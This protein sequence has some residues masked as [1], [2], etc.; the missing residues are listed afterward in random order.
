MKPAPPNTLTICIA[1]A[2]FA[3]AANLLPAPLAVVASGLLL[4]LL[5]AEVD[6]SGRLI[7]L[8]LVRSAAKLLPSRIREGNEAQWTDHVLCAGEMGLRPV[9]VALW[10]V[11]M[12]APRLAFRYRVRTRAA[13]YVGQ[14]FLSYQDVEHKV[15][16]PLRPI[17]PVGVRRL[18]RA[19]AT[20]TLALPGATAVYIC[21]GDTSRFPAS[22]L[23]VIGALMWTIPI[24]SMALL[25]GGALLGYA[26][27][28][29]MFT[30]T[31]GILIGSRVLFTEGFAIRV[32]DRIAG[33]TDSGSA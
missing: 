10:I 7:A 27:I 5:A 32:V 12:G 2:A 21:S 9:V 20:I 24:G 30:F 14:L 19:T 16:T 4:A 23:A 22:L 3:A 33:R 8:R 15:I 13:I 18:V 11:F 31:L 25:P 29:V 26:R 28:I 6:R 17:K 1:L